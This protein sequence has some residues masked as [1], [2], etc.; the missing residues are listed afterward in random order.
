MIDIHSHILPS[1]DDGPRN[2]DAALKLCRALV[3]D[4]VRTAVATPHLIDGVFENVASRVTPLVGELN[5][6]LGAE[7]V[8]LEVLAGA[9]V[10]FSSRYVAEQI[11]ELPLLG[12]GTAV[13]L[14]MPVAVIPPAIQETIFALRSRG[15]IPVIAHPER[16][17]LLQ[18]R[19]DLARAWID[20]GALLQLDGDSLLGVWGRHTQRC[21]EHLLRSGLFHA[22]ASDAHSVDSR[23]PRLRASLQRAVEL[24]GEGARALVTDGPAMILA[25]RSIRT[26]LY[27]IAAQPAADTREVRRPRGGFF[28]WLFDRSGDQL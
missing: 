10:D 27:E 9:E 5:E 6:R 13:L 14:E 25:G 7:G 19:P 18:D 22:M 12:G 20:A 8:E 15:L 4:G 3:E 23:P 16:N 28:S 24:V 2:W 26:P 21:A 17:E 11:H 1:I